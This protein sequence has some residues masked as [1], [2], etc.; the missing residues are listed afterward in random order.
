[1]TRSAICPL[2]LLLFSCVHAAVAQQL[3]QLKLAREPVDLLNGRLTVRVPEKGRQVQMQRSIMAAP[4]ANTEMSRVVVD[5]G[6]Q[7]LVI[8]ASEL[9]ARRDK[10][11]GNA[12][13]KKAATFAEKVGVE[14]CAVAPPLQA[15]CYAPV[16][17]THDQEANLVLGLFVA[18]ADATVE[19]LMFFVNQ[20]G[21][22]NLGDAAGLAKSIVRTLAAGTRKLESTAGERELFAYSRDSAVFVT[23]PE[24]YVATMQQGPDFLVHH[25]HK[26]TGFGEIAASVGI[27]LGDHPAL[28]REGYQKQSPVVLLGKKTDWYERLDNESGVPVYIADAIVPLGATEAR[29]VPSYADVFLRA[30]DH[31][32][33]SELKT[34]AVTL[35]IGKTK[36]PK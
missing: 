6:K 4:E 31:D 7:R 10:E 13:R 33:I 30:R 24:G 12:V 3:G 11:F 17:P 9:F 15:Y 27:Y 32:G 16:V 34:I 36:K 14:E 8:V 25:L 22:R 20:S 5:A 2:A 26:I 19:H 28:G 29:E 1:M 23:V 21:A 35:R 18:Q